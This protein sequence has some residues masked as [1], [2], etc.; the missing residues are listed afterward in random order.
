[1]LTR[2]IFAAFAA[3]LVSATLIESVAAY[4]VT[5]RSGTTTV[6]GVFRPLVLHLSLV[7]ESGLLFYDAESEIF[8]YSATYRGTYSGTGPDYDGTV[9]GPSGDWKLTFDSN[10]ASDNGNSNGNVITVRPPN[11]ADYVGQLTY[12]GGGNYNGVPDADK[13]I[14]GDIF[15]LY[16]TPPSSQDPFLKVTCLDGL[17]L[18]ESFVMELRQDLLHLGPYYYPPSC[19]GECNPT[20][21]L[22]R[23]N[24]SCLNP[25]KPCGGVPKNGFRASSEVPEPASLALVGLGLAGL[26]MLRRKQTGRLV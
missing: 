13:A 1:M 15:F 4:P 18:C 22:D 20:L 17:S 21:D 12:L 7:D 5:A 23:V 24:E 11:Y 6:T 14:L 16:P 3:L 10:T 8:S 19:E 9:T 26:A 25:E 2:G